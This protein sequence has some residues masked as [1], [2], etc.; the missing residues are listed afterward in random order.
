MAT[1]VPVRIR[2]RATDA[3][4]QAAALQRS[5]DALR[6]SVDR[7]GPA[8]RQATTASRQFGATANREMRQVRDASS[9][10]AN[11][12]RSIRTLGRTAFL[13]FSGAAAV[14]GFANLADEGTRIESLFRQV[15]DS[16]EDLVAEQEN[17]YRLA[18]ELRVPVDSLATVF[19][20]T[21]LAL[22]DAFD[23]ERVRQFTRSITQLGVASGATGIEITNATRQ[24]L[25]GLGSGK[26]AGDE[27][28]GVLEGLP[29][30][31]RELARELNVPFGQLR[32]L[33]ASGALTPDRVFTALSGEGV[34][35]RA[36]AAFDAVGQTFE[37]TINIFR[38]QLVEGLRGNTE[39]VKNLDTVLNKIAA[40]GILAAIESIGE[41]AVG[42]AATGAVAL[43]FSVARYRRDVIATRAGASRTLSNIEQQL[44]PEQRERYDRL[45][46]RVGQQGGRIPT[47][48]ELRA[49]GLT[50]RQAASVREELR[51]LE[52]SR[53]PLRSL[54]RGALG[55]GP[56]LIDRLPRIGAVSGAVGSVVASAYVLWQ[57]LSSPGFALSD[58]Y[59]GFTSDDPLDITAGL[60]PEDPSLLYRSSQPLTSY[61]RRQ[62]EA[63]RRRSE[64][65]LLT[66]EQRRLAGGFYEGARYRWVRGQSPPSIDFFNNQEKRL[67]AFFEQPLFG[68]ER[69]GN[70][71]RI[72]VNRERR[73]QL[74]W[75]R[76]NAT[77]F[78][79]SDRERG[80][81]AA[82]FGGGDAFVNYESIQRAAQRAFATWDEDLEAW[83]NRNRETAEDV[84]QTWRSVWLD[85]GNFARESILT[86][87]DSTRGWLDLLQRGVALMIT[88]GNRN[89]LIENP[90][91]Q[92]S[93]L[94]NFITA[95]TGASFHEGYLPRNRYDGREIPAV[96]RANEFVL[97]G[98]Q[99]AAVTGGGGVSVNQQF[100]VGN[101]DDAIL[102]AA[103]R[104]GYELAAIVQ[105][106]SRQ[107]G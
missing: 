74:I 5:I 95:F 54:R 103:R 99:M 97:T 78:G 24:L 81:L 88:I 59:E 83:E 85:I 26:L 8:F 40:P 18:N 44:P 36:Q 60:D 84:A 10:I 75:E 3:A 106:A 66:P 105:R 71:A 77:D 79:I 72:L 55:A 68:Y 69:F 52:R 29:A 56:R 98:D 32:E 76:N 17:I 4:R 48:E 96:I 82:F 2:L 11:N 12:L 92:P 64:D 80:R 49:T 107:I 91:W 70:S 63:W 7:V 58:F 9:G 37:Q 13:G 51:Y 6:T 27:L 30:V 62:I 21:N 46:Q 34:A 22:G 65:Q 90:D 45:I 23:V 104:R 100:N 94:R 38:N 57:A 35:A 1:D 93:N 73:N 15:T 42:L 101:I 28:R 25:Q 16:T 39:A 47:R 19:A 87:E 61:Q 89:R 14:R 102:G 50:D 43:G 33:G 86:F 67:D 31:G 20:R 41:L 53:H